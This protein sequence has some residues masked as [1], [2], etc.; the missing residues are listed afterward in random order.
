MGFDFDSPTVFLGYGVG[1]GYN[2]MLTAGAIMHKEKRLKGQYDAND[3]VSENL[4]ADQLLDS[5]Y[6]PRAYVGLAFRF[7]A[8]PFSS[9]G[10]EPA[11]EKKGD[12]KPK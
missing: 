12:E 1:W 7:G 6:K 2:V 8:N 3:V 5:T 9:S 10:S 11:A 4:T